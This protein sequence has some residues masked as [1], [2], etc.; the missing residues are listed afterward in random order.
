MPFVTE[1]IY[2]MLPIKTH[3]SIMISD[4]PIYDKSLM[5]EAEE[6]L[7]DEKIEF[8]KNFRNVKSE[9]SIPKDALVKINTEDEIII[10]MLKL[11]DVLTEEDLSINSY[12]VKT[13]KY[14][15]TIYF[16]KQVTEEELKLK[17][18]Q[19]NDLESSIER[20]KKLLANENYVAKAPAELVEKERKT[21]ESEEE[22]LALLKK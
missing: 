15:A 14:Q 18:K 3:D 9:N 12:E 20:R 5:F 22:Q 19:I 1:E 17:E 7:V 13:Q 8:I 4:Y 11:S 16:E 2:Q 10:K 6:K 21:L